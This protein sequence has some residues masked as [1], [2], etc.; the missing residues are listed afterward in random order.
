MK[1]QYVSIT[2]Q[3]HNERV[4]SIPMNDLWWNS[5]E[6]HVVK[7]C[8]YIIKIQSQMEVQNF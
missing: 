8:V 6:V 4:E 5:L 3:V 7:H 1:Q 2:S